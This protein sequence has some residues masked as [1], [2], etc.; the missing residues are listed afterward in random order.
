MRIFKGLENIHAVIDRHDNEWRKE[1]G[2]EE[3]KPFT[4]DEKVRR[5]WEKATEKG[6]GNLDEE[7]FLNKGKKGK[8]KAEENKESEES[9]QST[10][11]EVEIV[12]VIKQEGVQHS[13]LYNEVEKAV[14]AA[15]ADDRKHTKVIAIFVPVIQSSKEFE[16]LPVD[17]STTLPPVEEEIPQE[18]STMPFE[19]DVSAE[20]NPVG[21]PEEN[22]PDEVIIFAKSESAAIEEN[23]IENKTE[24]EDLNE[25]EISEEPNLE[26]YSQVQE[27]EQQE[28]E[29]AQEITEEEERHD[30][31]LIPEA[32]EHPDEELAEAFSTME[33]KLAAASENE[34]NA[35]SE[36]EIE[37]EIEVEN[38]AEEILEENIEQFPAVEEQEEASPFRDEPETES[39]SETGLELETEFSE[40]SPENNEG[41]NI[42]N[43]EFD[44]EAA[45]EFDESAP[46]EAMSFEEFPVI[47]NDENENAEAPVADFIE[48]VEPDTFEKSEVPEE[49]EKINEDINELEKIK[50]ADEIK[51]E[52]ANSESEENFAEPKI[53]TETES[54]TENANGELT[55]ET[56]EE[57]TKKHD[58]AETVEP[59]SLE[60]F[61]DEEI[62]EESIENLN[63]SLLD[64][65]YDDDIENSDN[66]KIE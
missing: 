31:N 51:E 66:I 36:P 23:E 38:A 59:P 21:E 28:Q 4:P 30:F 61:D 11:P 3:V 35:E 55:L 37:T 18:D 54:E 53:G 26:E 25:P 47:K 20:E 27:Q 15:V 24:N 12:E 58:L 8:T 2:E 56:D 29:Q 48:E 34:I 45:D 49:L 65:E 43:S 64:S 5:A 40:S 33:E 10:P 14:R 7:R 46:G 57:E 63:D 9:E 22:E 32:Q 42:D 13:W 44:G 39:E 1:Q 17:E 19:I 50:E 16:D 41:G 52:A 60:D 6:K 62:F